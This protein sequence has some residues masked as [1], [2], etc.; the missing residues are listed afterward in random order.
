MKTACVV[1]S[2]LLL[3]LLSPS[4]AR[5]QSRVS[6]EVGGAVSAY[7]LNS[8]PGVAR[9]AIRIPDSSGAPGVGGNGVTTGGAPYDGIAVAEVRP[10]I[11]LDSGLLV[12]V[13]FRAGQAGLGDGGTSLV[14]GDLSLGF[15]H[16][17][18]VFIP[19]IKGMF[20]FNSYDVSNQPA[21]PHQTDLRLDAV[22]G[23]RLY[24]SQ[25][26]FLS[27]AVFA[28]WGDRYGG[29]VSVGADVVQMFRRGV[30]P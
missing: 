15:Q 12:G 28:G 21:A 5:A 2:A 4:Q 20:G 9:G 8:G 26:F 7:D 11:F 16:R 10:T 30:M 25:K 14:G 19:F 6:I 1:A 29:T 22:V 17:F 27:A 3:G 24:L 18:G 13:G 23:S